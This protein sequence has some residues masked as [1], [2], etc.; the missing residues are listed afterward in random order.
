M[1]TEIRFGFD[2]E[3]FARSANPQL[4]LCVQHRHWHFVTKFSIWPRLPKKTQTTKSRRKNKKRGRGKKEGKNQLSA[5]PSHII[6]VRKSTSA[7]LYCTFAYLSVFSAI[8]FAAVYFAALV[9]SYLLVRKL[10]S[11]NTY[12]I[13]PRNGPGRAAGHGGSF[14]IRRH[15]R[16]IQHILHQSS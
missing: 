2:K 3:C 10:I 16:R 7:S 14:L 4:I 11:T 12:K 1:W 8:Y 13:H 5:S 9:D 6:P 15:R